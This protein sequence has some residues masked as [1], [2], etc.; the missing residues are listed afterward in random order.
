MN[1]KQYWNKNSIFECWRTTQKT[2]Y[3]PSSSIKFFH[4]YFQ[5][6]SQLIQRKFSSLS[7]FSFLSISLKLSIK[8]HIHQFAHWMQYFLIFAAYTHMCMRIFRIKKSNEKTTR[9]NLCRN[10]DSGYRQYAFPSI[11]SCGIQ[12]SLSGTLFRLASTCGINFNIHAWKNWEKFLWLRQSH[13]AASVAKSTSSVCVCVRLPLAKLSQYFRLRAFLAMHCSTICHERAPPAA[14][15]T[16]LATT[17]HPGRYDQ[18]RQVHVHNLCYV[19]PPLPI[20]FQCW[21]WER[22]HC[23]SMHCKFAVMWGR[24]RKEKRKTSSK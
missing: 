10:Y 11:S 15:H 21:L 14:A 2:L 16:F 17:L 3:F 18:D 6:H 23:C 19:S 1:C 8:F 12:S 20:T 22:H 24:E 13:A 5:L 9:V 7:F 4:V